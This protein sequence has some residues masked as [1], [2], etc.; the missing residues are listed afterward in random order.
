MSS[1]NDFGV[2]GKTEVETA[3]SSASKFHLV[4]RLGRLAFFVGLII[5]PVIFGIALYSGFPTVIV[6]TIAL[7]WLVWLIA[8]I[9]GRA[10]DLDYSAWFSILIILACGVPVINGVMLIYLCVKSGNATKNEYG[11]PPEGSVAELLYFWR[12]RKI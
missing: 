3:D 8:I 6:N 5:A 2:N 7:V 1:F 10:H 11:L 4:G 9:I 12:P